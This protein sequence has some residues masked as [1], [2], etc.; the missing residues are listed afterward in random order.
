MWRKCRETV[1]LDTGICGKKKGDVPHLTQDGGDNA[2]A[3]RSCHESA[4]TADRKNHFAGGVQT[5]IPRDH[6]KFE[7]ACTID[8]TRT[9]ALV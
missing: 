3:S 1:T 6:E 8:V 4:S 2:V 7:A 5:I 9:E